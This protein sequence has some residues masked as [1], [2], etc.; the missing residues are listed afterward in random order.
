M[1]TT[2]DTSAV[3]SGSML[4]TEPLTGQELADYIAASPINSAGLPTAYEHGNR[5]TAEGSSVD[6]II[7]EI[8]DYHRK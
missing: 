2:A 6:P 7:V 5:L 3:D 8:V 1:T 4:R